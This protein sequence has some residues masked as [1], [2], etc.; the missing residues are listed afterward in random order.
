MGTPAVGTR[1]DKVELTSP[2]LGHDVILRSFFDFYYE[3][4]VEDRELPHDLSNFMRTTA[5]GR[6]S[7]AANF[8][9]WPGGARG[10]AGDGQRVLPTH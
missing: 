9:S 2:G 5:N 7:E 1:L 4:A 3:L 10:V 8:R 6:H